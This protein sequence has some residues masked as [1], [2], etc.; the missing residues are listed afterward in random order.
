MTSLLR[1]ASKAAGTGEGESTMRDNS[2][3]PLSAEENAF[4]DAFMYAATAVQRSV[5]GDLVYEQH[6]SLREYTVLSRMAEAPGQQLRIHELAEASTLSFS[7]ISRLVEKLESQGLLGR[8]P[9][10]NDRRGWNVM[11]TVGGQETL[12]KGRATYAA[13]VRSHVLNHIEPG[14][15][16]ALTRLIRRLAQLPVR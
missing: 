12:R 6:L 15:L 16:P 10:T 4:F 7:R 2:T 13:S 8:E 11:L 5:D 14:H 1:R 9:V 3:E